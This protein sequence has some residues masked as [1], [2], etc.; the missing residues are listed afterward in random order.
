MKK[1]YLL[2]I[3]ILILL[4]ACNNTNKN[5]KIIRSYYLDGT[6][7]EEV[8]CII[9]KNN[10]ENVE[11]IA[12][13]NYYPNGN[14]EKEQ[15]YSNNELLICIWYSKKGILEKTQEYFGKKGKDRI[16]I[17]KWY[18][19][20]G[21]LQKEQGYIRD[22]LKHGTYRYFSTEGKLIDSAQFVFNKYRNVIM[23]RPDGTLERYKAYDYIENKKFT[24]SYDKIGWAMYNDGNPICSWILAENYPLDKKLEIELLV[25]NPPRCKT[26]LLIYDFDFKTKEKTNKR[27][28]VP[29]KYNKI[30]YNMVQNSQKDVS[31]LHVLNISDTVM[32]NEVSDTLLITIFKDGKSTYKH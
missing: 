19:P 22:S 13:R 7:S 14:M 21:K 32:P 20:N 2:F 3:N 12:R 11:I 18:Y 23:Y 30:T 16:I 28:Y 25:A 24:I 5:H 1:L 31:I 15:K 4:T 6:V 26:E 17:C 10:M 29:D 9:K 8:E 27:I